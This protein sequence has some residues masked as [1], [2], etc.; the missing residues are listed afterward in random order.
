MFKPGD[1]I[2]PNGYFSLPLANFLKERF[3]ILKKT[4]WK[5]WKQETIEK[6]FDVTFK[7]EELNNARY[8]FYKISMFLLLSIKHSSSDKPV[9]MKI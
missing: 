8:W 5:S 9:A 6:S 7:I 3:W 1:Y 4:F 2:N